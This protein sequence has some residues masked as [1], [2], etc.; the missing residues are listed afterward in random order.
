MLDYKQRN[1]LSNKTNINIYDSKGYISDNN[2]KATDNLINILT[3]SFKPIIETAHKK[4]VRDNYST[5]VKKVQTDRLSMMGKSDMDL[6]YEKYFKKSL[7]RSQSTRSFNK[8]SPKKQPLKRKNSFLVENN[9]IDKRDIL[10]NPCN[11]NCINI[12]KTPDV[13]MQKEF[14]ER[15][16]MHSKNYEEKKNQMRTQYEKKISSELKPSPGIAKGSQRIIE[17]KNLDKRLPLYLRFKELAEEKNYKMKSIQKDLKRDSSSN[18]LNNRN[19]LLGKVTSA[20]YNNYNNSINNLNS[21]T[22][23]SYIKA[24]SDMVRSKSYNGKDFGDWLETNKMWKKMK[25]TKTENF[26]D[27]L[28]KII[29]EK[30]D[31]IITFRPS[32]NEKSRHFAEL[33]KKNEHEVTNI[34][35]RL[36]VLNDKK[37]EYIQNLQHK[38]KPTFKPNINKYPQFPNSNTVHQTTQSFYLEEKE[39]EYNITVSNVE[40]K[41]K[42]DNSS[43]NVPKNNK[44]RRKGSL[45]FNKFQDELEKNKFILQNKMNYKKSKKEIEEFFCKMNKGMSPNY[46]LEINDIKFCNDSHKN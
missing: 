29:K 12:S 17:N 44:P 38:Y 30:E 41:E 7:T 42:K 43:K 34:F 10:D 20:D 19:T 1:K 21:N 46:D 8:N 35:D 25:E 6:I 2:Q 15:E 32:I 36:Y 23:G 22:S 45:E 4:F 3:K 28:E 26:R 5:I 18:I 16:Q 9:I 11:K 40:I 27:T 24:A 37:K 13:S 39:D 31:K 33:K 14:Y